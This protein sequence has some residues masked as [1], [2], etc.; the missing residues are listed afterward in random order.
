LAM[1]VSRTSMKVARVTVTA[2]SHGLWEGR[3]RTV[4]AGN[5]IDAKLVHP[6]FL[7]R[8]YYIHACMYV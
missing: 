3:Q 1:E 8:S 7:T 4:S 2:T 6:L 5:A